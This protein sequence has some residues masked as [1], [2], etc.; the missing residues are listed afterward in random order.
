LR[1]PRAC[2]GLYDARQLLSLSARP[3]PAGAF[4]GWRGGCL[5]ATVRD[6]VLDVLTHTSIGAGFE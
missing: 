5:P 2:V 4:R 6:C 1:C 3:A